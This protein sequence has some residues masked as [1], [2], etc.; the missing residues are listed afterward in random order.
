MH[1]RI[2][3]DFCH[4]VMLDNVTRP[5]AENWLL[6]RK[7]NFSGLESFIAIEDIDDEG[8]MTEWYLLDQLIEDANGI[9]RNLFKDF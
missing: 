4:T 3:N 8:N 1:S 2:V 9:D 7:E 5:E 6:E